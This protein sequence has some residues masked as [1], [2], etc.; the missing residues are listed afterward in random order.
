MS[1]I[2]ETKEFF[3]RDKQISNGENADKEIGFPV[4]YKIPDN[5]GGFKTV[6]NRFLKGHYPSESVFRK[7]FNSVPFFLN[8]DSTATTNQQGLTKIA[9]SEQIKNGI[10]KDSNGFQLAVEPSKTTEIENSQIPE[11]IVANNPE[12]DL[13]PSIKEFP[14]E[15]DIKITNVNIANKGKVFGVRIA[16]KFIDWIGKCLTDII[17]KI[18]R[19]G[20]RG[21]IQYVDSDDPDLNTIEGEITYRHKNNTSIPHQDAFIFNIIAKLPKHS[22]IVNDWFEVG[23]II[24]KVLN[25]GLFGSDGKGTG[26]YAKWAIADGRN[27]TV[28]MRGYVMAQRTWLQPGESFNN[29]NLHHGLENVGDT[30]GSSIHQLNTNEIPEHDHDY[31]TAIG[32]AL[33]KELESGGLHDV[34]TNQDDLKTDK[35]GGNQPHNNMQPTMAVLVIQ[36]IL[37]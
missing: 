17:Y 14:Y 10:N 32:L 28:D 16:N 33:N 29:N 20:I 5:K 23:D 12:F 36:K 4:S 2:K 24:I 19:S 27:G 3:L 34:L 31:K 15:E 37:L 11:E 22:D 30:Y 35:T 13:F 25:S 8:K 7:L 26:K 9:T 1:I 6:F 18:I 21:E